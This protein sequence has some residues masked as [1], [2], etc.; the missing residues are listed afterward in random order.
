MRCGTNRSKTSLSQGRAASGGRRRRW[1][2]A[3]NAG[4]LH[5]PH[6]T[7]VAACLKH[8]STQALKHSS[9]QALKH[10]STQAL[11][12][13]APLATCRRL[14]SQRSEQNIANSRHVGVEG[15]SMPDWSTG[16]CRFRALAAHNQ[17]SAVVSL[18]ALVTAH[19]DRRNVVRAAAIQRG[20]DQT[21]DTLL[22][23]AIGLRQGCRDG[24]IVHFFGQ[25]VAA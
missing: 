11:K 5:V 3:A 2:V 16:T 12:L 21:F 20:G 15:A 14:R 4:N 9:T 19:Q 17:R 25:A 22:R 24:R 8:S 18:T 1:R 13:M 10:S 23:T 6:A 7:S